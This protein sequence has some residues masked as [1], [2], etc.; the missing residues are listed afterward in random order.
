MRSKETLLR[1]T[2]SNDNVEATPA[3]LQA[4]VIEFEQA[5]AIRAFG[6]DMRVLLTTETTGGAIS[7]LMAWHKPG[8]GPPDHVHFNK[9]E[10]FFVLEGSYELTVGGET[11]TAAP[12]LL[13]SSRVTWCI[14]SRT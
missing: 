12:A 10:M 9:E 8:Q 11:K 1:E 6:L 2:L 14:V 4:A 5:P 13:Y 3:P 7:V